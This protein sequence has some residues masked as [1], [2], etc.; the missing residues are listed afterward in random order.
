MLRIMFPTCS[1]KNVLDLFRLDGKASYVTGGGQGL[2]EA[3]AVALAQAGSAVAVVDVNPVTAKEVA[4][5][6]CGFGGH[7]IYLKADVTNSGEVASMI[8]GVVDAFGQLDIA[9][10]NA[11]IAQRGPAQ[12]VCDEDWKRI[13]DVNLNG[14]FFCAREAG[15]QMIR[16][17]HGGSIINTASMSG[18]IVN[19]GRTVAAY[20]T[21]KAGVKHL[22]KAL[23]A[24]WAKHGIRVNSISPGYMKTPLIAKSLQDPESARCMIDTTP[25]ARIGEPW[26]LAGTVVYLASQASSF[27]TGHDLIVDGGYTVW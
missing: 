20:C 6:I 21:T 9:V 24:E 17:G 16:Q 19:K 13:V 7:A 14:V 5:R 3:M 4:D 2:G 15:R 1:R 23:A 25:M 22:T 27:V 26:E 18:S 11:G 8:R 12:E 10:N